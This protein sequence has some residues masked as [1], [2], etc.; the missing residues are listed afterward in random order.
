V[1]LI[2]SLDNI[3]A[4]NLPSCCRLGTSPRPS[5]SFHAS[6]FKQFTLLNIYIVI[7]ILFNNILITFPL[8]FNVTPESEESPLLETINTRIIRTESIFN[9]P[10]KIRNSVDGNGELFERT[11]GLAPLD[12]GLDYRSAHESLF[13]TALSELNR[14]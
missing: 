8:Y 4:K 9:T 10:E 2:W 5:S 14:L 7:I 13:L 1:R 6:C 11:N 3:S 12:R